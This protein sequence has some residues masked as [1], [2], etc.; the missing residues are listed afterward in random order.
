[1]VQKEVVTGLATTKLQWFMDMT[2]PG[3]NPAESDVVSF[4]I[5]DIPIA[6]QKLP[7]PRLTIGEGPAGY[8]NATLVSTEQNYEEVMQYVFQGFGYDGRP[9]SFKREDGFVQ[10]LNT[11]YSGVYWS[12]GMTFSYEDPNGF[13]FFG[14]SNG[15]NLQ[16]ADDEA[17][18]GATVSTNKQSYEIGETK[19]I[20][21]D[22]LNSGDISA[23]DVKVHLFQTRLGRD[24]SIVEDL[25]YVDSFDVGTVLAGGSSQVITTDDSL[26]FLGY[27]GYFALIEGVSDAGQG[28]EVVPDFLNLGITQFDDGE[29][30]RHWVMS[31][32]SGVVTLP[33]GFD[34]RCKRR[35]NH[36]LCR[37][38]WC[39]RR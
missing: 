6:T 14:V 12:P 22:I 33:Q 25:W 23:E 35:N 9:L 21:I 30:A 24:N 11:H 5:E 39:R 17:V 31:T 29:E 38:C 36:D 8:P 1:M 16:I 28:P 37:C 13:P 34:L 18:L 32:M 3:L 19:T 4:S 7:L 26:S 10:F 27:S 2:H 15:Q 20:T